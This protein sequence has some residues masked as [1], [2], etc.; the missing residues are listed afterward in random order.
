M[1]FR[2][3]TIA[4]R[5]LRNSATI[6]VTQSWGPSIAAIPA[7]CEKLAVHEF[8]LTISCTTAVDEPRR[9]HP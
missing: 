3:L 1:V 4:S 8:E 5:R 6:A 2:P 7:R 9:H